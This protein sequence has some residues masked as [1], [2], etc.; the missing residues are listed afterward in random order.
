MQVTKSTTFNVV[1]KESDAK[2]PVSTTV[3]G[4]LVTLSDEE[5]QVC[6]VWSR[7]RDGI[8]SSRE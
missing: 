7:T 1:R 5:R 2:L 4:K 3:D 6:E 8:F